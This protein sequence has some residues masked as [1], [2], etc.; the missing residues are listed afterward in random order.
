VERFH[1]NQ[2][3]WLI[4]FYVGVIILVIF[5]VFVTL[6]RNGAL[7]SARCPFDLEKYEN[8]E[9]LKYLIPAVFCFYTALVSIIWGVYIRLMRFNEE[10]GTKYSDLN[11][12]IDSNYHVTTSSYDFA[13][14]KKDYD[15]KFLAGLNFGAYLYLILSVSVFYIY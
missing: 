13:N 2:K 6:R 4:T 9:F 10:I 15:L 3:G 12:C 1:R 14:E 7:N 5:V 11:Q 8:F